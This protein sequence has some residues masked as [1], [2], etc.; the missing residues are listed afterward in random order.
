MMME[1]TMTET[2]MNETTMIK[3]RCYEKTD[4]EQI[5]ALVLHCQNDGTRPF[6][7]LEDQ[8]ELL[9]IQ[10]K[11]ID[12]GGNFWV[13]EEDGRIAGSIGLMNYGNGTGILKKFFVYETYRSSPHHLGRRLYN[14]LLTFAKEHGYCTLVLDTPKNTDRAHRF[15]ENAGFEKI[16]REQLGIIYDYPYE[17]SDFF[18]LQVVDASCER[19]AESCGM[20]DA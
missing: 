19:M 17:D 13:A 14:V 6:V 8:P 7:T 9:H 10:E 16:G 4:M 3:I 15:Y 5:I 12:G 1:T 20:I 2:T 11:Y 18:R